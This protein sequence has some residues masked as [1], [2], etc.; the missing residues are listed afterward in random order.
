MDELLRVGDAQRFTTAPLRFEQ[1]PTKHALP[2][3]LEFFAGSGLVAHGLKSFF[4]AE[5]ANDIDGKKAAVY[6]ANHGAEHFECKSIADVHG[7]ELPR[8]P[9]AWASFP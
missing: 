2:S 4:F 8:A 1:E 5:W 7:T 9:L 6:A 3:F